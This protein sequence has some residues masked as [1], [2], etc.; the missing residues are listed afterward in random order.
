MDTKTGL[1]SFDKLTEEDK[2]KAIFAAILSNTLKQLNPHERFKK[3]V[4]SVVTLGT[5][6]AATIGLIAVSVFLLKWLFTLVG[7]L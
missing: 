3:W 7:I 4:G 6:V 5:G 2:Q 1:E